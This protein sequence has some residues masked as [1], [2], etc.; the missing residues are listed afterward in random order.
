MWRKLGKILAA[1]VATLVLLFVASWTVRTNRSIGE[2]EE[3]Q[4]ADRAA[5]VYG[6]RLRAD[7][8]RL[9]KAGEWEDALS[10]YNQAAE[11]DRGLDDSE[12]K[13]LQVIKEHVGEV[14]WDEEYE[15]HGSPR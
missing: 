1:I 13:K 12:K 6:A 4:A 2:R 3:Q 15:A 7:G 11:Y 5:H 10:R 14:V 8:D 9:A